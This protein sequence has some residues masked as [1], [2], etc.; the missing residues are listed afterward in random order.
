MNVYEVINMYMCNSKVIKSINNHKMFS[1]YLI[2][3]NKR[4]RKKYV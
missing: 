4:T 2:Q 1:Q 3:S